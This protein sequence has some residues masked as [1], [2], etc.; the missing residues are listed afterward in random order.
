MDIR[1]SNEFLTAYKRLKKKY[2]S[3]QSDFERLLKSLQENPYQG[4]EIINGV[5]K[6]RLSIKA[7]G[8]GKSGGARV[9][10]RIAIVDDELQFLYIYDKSEFAN[11]SDAFLRDILS[12]M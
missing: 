2:R 5:W 1:F 11:V 8:K 6:M 9:I 10:I 4:V 12:Q 3:L 7:K